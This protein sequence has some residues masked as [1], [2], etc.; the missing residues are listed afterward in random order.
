MSSIFLI[1][2]TVHDTTA[3]R[4]KKFQAQEYTYNMLTYGTVILLSWAA[5][6]LVWGI[7]A[8][9]IKRDIKGG[10]VSSL[11]YWYWLLR[12]ALVVLVV[13]VL[14]RITTGSAH[15]TSG[16]S[17]IFRSILFMPPLILGWFAAFL[18]ALGVTFAIWARVHLGRNWSAAPAIKEN[19]E[20]VVSGPYR[21]VR[22]PIYTG[23]ILA[24]FGA[25]LTG[26]VFGIGVFVAAS[27]QPKDS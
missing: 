1:A 13:F 6:I 16:N 5:F 27:S 20:L 17:I 12:F 2:V 11:W 19:H 7:G 14:F 22:H 18:C 25:A 9:N 8:F 21:W 4:K 10:G 24:A 3:R 23:V 15:F 26:T